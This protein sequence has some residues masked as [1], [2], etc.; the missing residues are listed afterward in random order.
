MLRF[1]CFPFLVLLAACGDGVPAD[2][3]T[4]SPGQKVVT[5]APH[6]AEL[7]FAI[8]AESQLVATVAYSDYPPAAGDIPVIGDA[9]RVDAERLAVISPDL[10]LVWP[11][12]NPVALIESLRTSGYRVV[13][14]EISDI[15]SV[16]EQIERVGE[17]TGHSAQAGRIAAEYR[18]QISDLRRQYGDRE[19]V[20]VFYQI[21]AQPLF[22]IGGTQIISDVIDLCRGVNI[23]EDLDELAPVVGV[24]SVLQRDPEVMISGGFNGENPLTIWEQFEEL[25]AVRENRLYLID[26]ALLARAGPRM[27]EGAAEVCRVID[28]ARR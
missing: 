19:P 12:G 15:A 7:M 17:L 28:L 18:A 6:L 9:F 4:A 2:P 11:Q 3:L 22:T 25:T 10:I 24:E 20:R 14:L 16:A 1:V 26:A 13:E 23:F 21:S 5:L 27:A 8:G